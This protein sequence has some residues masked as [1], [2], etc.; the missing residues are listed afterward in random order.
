MSSGTDPWVAVGIRTTG[1]GRP[2]REVNVATVYTHI[3]RTPIVSTDTIC[4]HMISTLTINRSR[5][6]RDPPTSPPTEITAGARLRITR[7]EFVDLCKAKRDTLLDL[8]EGGSPGGPFQPFS[9]AHAAPCASSRATP[10]SRPPSSR[11]P[12]NSSYTAKRPLGVLRKTFQHP[13]VTCLA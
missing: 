13:P 9:W 10:P 2:I 5:P 6:V 4:L 1:H 7:Y 11:V 12:Y 3:F 8:F